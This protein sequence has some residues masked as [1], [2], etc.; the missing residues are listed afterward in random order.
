MESTTVL[1]DGYSVVLREQEKFSEAE[2]MIRCAVDLYK[3][4]LGAG[5]GKMDSGVMSYCHYDM[6]EYDRLSPARDHAP[7]RTGNAAAA[8]RGAVRFAANR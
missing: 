5:L 1:A 4:V 3:E 8:C 7:P 6:I 2:E